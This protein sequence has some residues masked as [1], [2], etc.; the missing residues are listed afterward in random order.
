MTACGQNGLKEGNYFLLLKNNKTI[1][2]NTFENNKIKEENTYPISEKS[3][4][5]TDQKE[6]VAILDTAKIQLHFMNFKLQK[7]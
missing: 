7:K 4:F 3:I 2:L 1:S 5:T 6:R